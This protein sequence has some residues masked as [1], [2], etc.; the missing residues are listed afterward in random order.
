MNTLGNWEF[1]PTGAEGGVHVVMR[2]F[3]LRDQGAPDETPR[4][5]RA[6]SG[7]APSEAARVCSGRGLGRTRS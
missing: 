4:G 7:A 2:K 5:E 1:P 3:E 6:E